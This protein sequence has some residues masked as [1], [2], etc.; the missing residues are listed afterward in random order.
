MSG[1]ESIL[2]DLR[3]TQRNGPGVQMRTWPLED[4]FN[5]SNDEDIDHQ[6][7]QHVQSIMEVYGEVCEE[8]EDKE[9]KTSGE[10]GYSMARNFEHLTATSHSVL[11]SSG[12][13]G[14]AETNGGGDVFVEGEEQGQYARGTLRVC[15]RA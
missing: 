11:E 3:H 10:P 6:Q 13:M 4:E 7:K 5:G 12:G 1:G 8:V 9:D 15:V 2:I 14:K